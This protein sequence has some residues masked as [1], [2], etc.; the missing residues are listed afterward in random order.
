MWLF[1]KQIE[2]YTGHFTV[3]HGHFLFITAH[4]MLVTP[5]L[6]TGTNHNSLSCFSWLLQQRR[7]SLSLTLLNFHLL[8]LLD[9]CGFWI[10]RSNSLCAPC[11]RVVRQALEVDISKQLHAYE[12]E[13]HVLQDEMVDAAPLS[14]ESDRLDRLEKTN[15]QLKK[16]NMDLLEKLQVCHCFHFPCILIS[17][18]LW[19]TFHSLNRFRYVWKNKTTKA[20][21]T[22]YGYVW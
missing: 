11:S 18:I 19:Y 15:T 2:N 1:A 12:V 20:L 13:Y 8:V 4:V 14:E 5:E 6:R 16:Q 22:V 9:F 21:K 10:T 17:C 3:M 7:V